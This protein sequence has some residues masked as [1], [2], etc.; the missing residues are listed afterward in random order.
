M[1]NVRGDVTLKA[2]GKTYRLWLGMSVLAELQAEHG[3]DFLERMEPPKDAAANWMPPLTIVRDT[4]IAALQR[5]H[6]DEADRWLVDDI[7]AENGDAFEALMNGSG[8]DADAAHA[9]KPKA[10][11]AAARR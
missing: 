2:R 11:K 6:A 3:D 7:M 5:Y 9:G 8:P 4:F 1:A 10:R